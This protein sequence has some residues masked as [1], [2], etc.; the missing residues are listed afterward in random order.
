[1]SLVGQNETSARV[2]SMSGLPLNSGHPLPAQ[3]LPGCAKSG[4]EQMQQG[5]PLFDQFISSGKQCRRD[6]DAERPPSDAKP[7]HPLSAMSYCHMGFD[8]SSEAIT[9]AI[10]GKCI[11]YVA[12]NLCLCLL[13][14]ASN[15]CCD[16][17]C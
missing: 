15:C 2:G 5:T 8:W 11:S 13:I 17:G 10:G 16:R 6:F 14:Q 4:C 12:S 1:M 7:E 3:L 9:N